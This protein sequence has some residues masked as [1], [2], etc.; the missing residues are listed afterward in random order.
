MDNKIIFALTGASLVTVDSSIRALNEKHLIALNIDADDG[1]LERQLLIKFRDGSGVAQVDSQAKIT[2]IRGRRYIK[3]KEVSKW[4]LGVVRAVDFVLIELEDA[5]DDSRAILTVVENAFFTKLDDRDP[6]LR[7]FA[8]DL[9]PVGTTVVQAP[10]LLE[11]LGKELRSLDPELYGVHAET[12][13]SAP[14]ILIPLFSHVMTLSSE[15]NLRFPT[16]LKKLADQFRSLLE[17]PA[18]KSV[19]IGRVVKSHRK[20]WD[21][22]NGSSIAFLD[23]G[24]ARIA[25]LPGT[26]PLALR[27]G[28]YSVKPGERDLA[29][30]EEWTLN[31][32]VIGEITTP[33]PAAAGAFKSHPDA[34]R[35][36]EAAR[37]VLEPLAGLEFLRKNPTTS[38]LF[39]HGPLINQFTQYDE[40]E[41]NYLPCIKDGFLAKHEITRAAVE[42]MVGPIPQ[43]GGQSLWNQ[44]MAVYGTIANRVMGHPTPIV[45]VVE[46]TVGSWLTNEVLRAFVHDGLINELYRKKVIDDIVDRYEI[47]DDFLFGCVLRE[48]EYLTPV[49]LIGKNLPRRARELWQD[50][51]GRYPAPLATVLKTSDTSFPFRVELNSSAA[52]SIENVADVLYHTA[53]LLPRYAFPVGLDIVD[54]LAKIPDWI[55]NGISSR[56]AADVLNRALKTGDPNVVNQVRL[57]LARSPRDFFYRPKA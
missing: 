7:L 26:D 27:V 44:F 49:K 47:S 8:Y 14:H 52:H 55:S 43:L 32:Y 35:L 2:T 18:C 37:Y 40:G 29:K 1:D 23:G 56:I 3:S 6:E 38:S 11:A 24:L 46:R 30:R 4:I 22:V 9:P 10:I 51:V 45:G 31:P 48:G 28:I 50:V 42:E 53:R 17:N 20:L 12:F 57:F 16:K 25:S 33:P 21:R 5:I 13:L 39:A 41:P 19:R 15:D 34:K 36:Q 54:K